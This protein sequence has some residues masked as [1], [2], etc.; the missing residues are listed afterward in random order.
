MEL[1]DECELQF[2]VEFYLDED[3]DLYTVAEGTL[4][5]P[6]LRDAV[7]AKLREVADSID[8]YAD[9]DHVH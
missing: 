3:G 8:T 4:D 2:A 9:P 1:P 5:T 6:V 7:A